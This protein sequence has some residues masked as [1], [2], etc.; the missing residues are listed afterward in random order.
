[1]SHFSESFE[2]HFIFLCISPADVQ[3]TPRRDDMCTPHKWGFDKIIDGK[4]NSTESF[5]T[6]EK[7]RELQ[8]EYI[9]VVSKA[10]YSAS[11][12]LPSGSGLDLGLVQVKNCASCKKNMDI[13]V[14]LKA[15]DSATHTLPPG[16]D[17]RP[18]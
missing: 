7:F 16:S 17:L 15:I 10:T 6:G 12:S 4:E 3:I 1:M 11:H 9:T 5:C 8:E 14:V 13:R 18:L 2:Q